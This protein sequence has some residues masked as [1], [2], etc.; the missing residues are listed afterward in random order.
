MA[1][2]GN[3]LELVG[4]HAHYGLSHVLHG[5]SLIVPEGCIT[6]IVGRNGVGKTTLINTIMGLVPASAGTVRYG[7][8]DLT[9]LPAHE[10][11]RLGLGLVPQ[12][13]R[14]FR[15]LTVEEHLRLVPPNRQS[16]FTFDQLYDIFPRL[17][18]RRT[19]LART[20]SGGEQSML[21]IARALSGSPRLLLMDEPTEGLAPLLVATVRDVVLRLRER[22]VTVLLVEQNLA[23]AHAVAD[24]VAI[25][26]RGQVIHL[27]ERGEIPRVDELG[28][29]M[30][31]LGSSVGAPAAEG[32]HTLGSGRAPFPSSSRRTTA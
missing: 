21:A 20:L 5:V 4:V 18:E 11:Q 10:R 22:G 14:I 9:R 3:A 29:L 2:K 15:T 24:R 6:A 1:D 19:S 28:R 8:V 12:G 23:F 26:D 16:L 25:M 17:R 27:F 13:R 7:R 30:L 31:A 32:P